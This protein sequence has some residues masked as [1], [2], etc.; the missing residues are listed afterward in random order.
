MNGF[1]FS[2][3]TFFFSHLFAAAVGNPSF[4]SILEEGFLIPDTSWANLQVGV[5]GDALFQQRFTPENSNINVQQAQI[6]GRSYIGSFTWNI[7]ERV[8]LEGAIGSGQF[9]WGWIQEDH[10]IEGMLKGGMIWSAGVKAVIFE[11][12]DTSFAVDGQ[13]GGWNWM[14]GHALE[15]GMVLS[16]KASSQMKYWQIAA[17]L[18]QR[19]LLLIPYLGGVVNRS[20]LKIEPGIGWLKS[21]YY[22]GLFIGCTLSLGTD[23]ALNGEWRGGFEQGFSLSGQLRF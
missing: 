13:I 17:A 14:D 10:S 12:K 19:I 4:P 23:I 16:K 1:K 6:Q 21:K 7:L 3:L 20:K 2:F 18:S 22:L 9:S 11:I 15:D 8:N 5:V